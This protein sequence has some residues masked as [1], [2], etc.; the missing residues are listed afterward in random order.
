MTVDPD[1]RT[2]C[3]FIFHI[4]RVKDSPEK[5]LESQVFCSVAMAQVNLVPISEIRWQVGPAMDS[6]SMLSSGHHMVVPFFPIG[7]L[8]AQNDPF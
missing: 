6:Q 7:R 8:S 3:H 4:C 1:C 5:S 2:V